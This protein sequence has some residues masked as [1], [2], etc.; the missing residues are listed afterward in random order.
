M[1]RINKQIYYS[2]SKSKGSKYKVNDAVRISKNKYI[3]DKGYTPNWTTEVFKIV[4]VVKTKPYTY[5]LQDFKGELIAGGFYEEELQK[6]KYPDIYLIEKVI[7]RNENKLFVK[8]LGFDDTHNSW[9]NKNDLDDLILI[10]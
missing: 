5:H 10:F 7:K 9:I 6:T 3:F 2:I 1:K 4:K 8:W